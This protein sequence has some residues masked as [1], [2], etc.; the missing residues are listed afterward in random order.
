MWG[1]SFDKRNVI[2]N[3]IPYKNFQSNRVIREKIRRACEF[4]EEDIVLGFVGRFGDEKNTSFLIRILLSLQKISK[5]YKLLTVGG[6]GRLDEFLSE[7]ERYG[8]NADHYS[9][10]VQKC[11]HEWYQAMD[12]FLLP[13]FFEGFP[14]VAIEAQAAGLPCFLSNR[15]TRE[16]KIS[17]NVYFLPIRNGDEILWAQTIHKAIWK[18]RKGKKSISEKYNITYAAKHLEKRYQFILKKYKNEDKNHG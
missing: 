18:G 1:Q 13:S 16:V 12:G 14:V 8:L 11:S 17:E 10:G 9:A 6:N 5:K 2:P 7:I 4:K 15:I 3:A